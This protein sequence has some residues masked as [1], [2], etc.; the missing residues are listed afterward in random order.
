YDTISRATSTEPRSRIRAWH[1]KRVSRCAW[2]WRSRTR[3]AC[4]NGFRGPSFIGRPGPRRSRHATGCTTCK[5]LFYNYID[6]LAREAR[7]RLWLFSRT[8][9]SLRPLFGVAVSRT[10]ERAPGTPLVASAAAIVVG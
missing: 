8:R 9:V 3:R 2:R 5:T 10:S 7:K 1:R 6:D 4:R